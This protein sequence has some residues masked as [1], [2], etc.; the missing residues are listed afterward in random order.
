MVCNKP[1]LMIAALRGGSGKTVVSLGLMAAWRLNRGLRVVPFK[2]GPDYIDASWLSTAARHPCYNLDPY[3]MQPN[4]ILAS[5]I[6]RSEAGHLSLIEGNRGLY[7]GVDVQ[8]SFSTA[9]LAKLLGAPVILVLDATK[10]TRTAAAMVLGCQQ[11]D[12]EVSIAGVILNQ[13]A[14]RRHE[15]VARGAIETYCRVPVVGVIPKDVHN[16]FPERH[17]GLV[18]PQESRDAAASMELAAARMTE[19]V[20]LDRLWEIASGA[21]TLGLPV[22]VFDQD[23]V[24]RRAVQP[25]IGVVRDA[26]F[27]FYYPENI[28]VLKELGAKVVEISS[29]ESRGLPV[30][31]ALYIGGG[32]PETHLEILAGNAV[33]RESVRAEVDRGLPVYAECGGLMFLCRSISGREGR[34]PMAGVFPHDVVME[35]KPQGHGYTRCEC[36]GENPFFAKGETFKG[37]EFHYSRLV[38]GEKAGPFVFRLVKGHGIIAGWD[39]MCYKRALACYSHIHAVGNTRWAGA[40]IA[41][42]LAYRQERHHAALDRRADPDGRASV[43]LGYS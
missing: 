11:M 38:D 40:M 41:A 42:A 20:D 5:F 7:D 28:E 16:F 43:L 6:R 32:F 39:G 27:Q 24:S 2:K 34:F 3:L 18:P 10:V 33:F 4:E 31:D 30:L 25:V 36:T 35:A 22:G 8:G 37:H 19:N 12:R 14:G 13:V 15:T 21:L 1:R 26:A 17:L 23:T 9:E 29:F